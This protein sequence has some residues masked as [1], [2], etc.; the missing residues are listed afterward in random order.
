MRDAVRARY[1]DGSESWSAD[2]SR[3]DRD[4]DGGEDN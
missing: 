2:D 4:G 3:L 1:L